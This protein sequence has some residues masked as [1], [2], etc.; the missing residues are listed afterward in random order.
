MS[1]NHKKKNYYVK[2][3]R[4]SKKKL[5]ETCKSELKTT[6]KI[7]I[8]S[9]PNEVKL[10]ILKF[11]NFDQ[12]VSVQQTNYYFYCLI[13][14]NERMLA[15]RGLYSVHTRMHLH[16]EID[17]SIVDIDSGI[18]KFSLDDRLLKKWQ[19]AVDRQ[20]PTY[21][22]TCPT[23]PG[24]D[25]YTRVD[26]GFLEDYREDT[27][28]YFILKLPVYPKNIEEMKIVRCWLEKLFLCY[29][30]SIRFKYGPI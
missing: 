17:Y 26:L 16:E 29:F 9:L 30:E 5:K 20:I 3:M 2:R 22:N 19:S 24:S 12:L 13:R 7:E 15:C 1:K 10:D 27:E 28:D 23:P 6:P 4:D 11:L 21:L 25:I 14:Q 8:L 18:F